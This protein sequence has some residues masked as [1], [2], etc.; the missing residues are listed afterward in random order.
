MITIYFKTGSDEEF[1]QIDAPKEGSWIHVDEATP[2]DIEQICEI[3]GLEYH[4]L[5]D[6]LDKYE[7][8]RIEQINQQVLIYSRYPIEYDLGLYTTTLTFILTQQ[9]FITICPYRSAFIQNFLSQKNKFST[10]QPSKLL[11]ELL[12]KIVQEFTS[13]IRRVRHNVLRQEKEMISVES[14]DITALTKH[15]EILNQYLSTLV[16]LR[17]VIELIMTGKYMVLNE[18]EKHHERLEDLRNAISQSVELCNIVIKSIRSLRDSY[19]IIFTNNLHKTIKL[20][21]ALTIIFNIPT[22]IASIYGMNVALPFGASEHAFLI[23]MGMTL[24][25]SIAGLIWFRR[26]KWL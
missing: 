7:I 10:H 2:Q 22:V 4:D 6:C 24:G 14:D 21:T 16:P 17:S 8:P 3:T 15:E 5:Q 1:S 12:F 23:I 18:S 26:K 13:Q 19:Q 11:I 25:L 20:L 9:Y